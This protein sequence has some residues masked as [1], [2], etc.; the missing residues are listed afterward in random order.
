VFYGPGNVEDCLGLRLQCNTH[1]DD[2]EDFDMS[3]EQEET[4]NDVFNPL[5][6]TRRHDHNSRLLDIQFMPGTS[7]MAVGSDDGYV[8]LYGNSGLD[9]YSKGSWWVPETKGHGVGP[10][11]WGRHRTAH[12]MFA[13]TEPNDVQSSNGYHGFCDIVKLKH[14]QLDATE[15]GDAIAIDPTGEQL[16]L[17]TS[18][19]KHFLRLYDLRDYK[20]PKAKIT[21]E[22]FAALSTVDEVT[23]PSFSNDGRLLAVPRSDNT[24]HI[25]DTCFLRDPLMT[26]TH[27]PRM[28]AHGGAFGV[29]KAE[30]IEGQLGCRA[31]GLLTGGSDGCVRLWDFDL[32]PQDPNQGRI[33]AEVSDDIAHFSFG[34]PTKHENRL[35]IGDTKGD[36]HIFNSSY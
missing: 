27:G 18:C 8:H 4:I 19:P 24:T 29:V 32:A 17:F 31:R 10:L 16:A 21:L 2:D 7:I 28:S 5:L 35:V 13:S 3:Y 15:A 22:S 30:W 25:Y 14:F 33:L 36:V 20:H 9:R 23:S 1:T 34:D 26:F 11:A 6:P 12:F